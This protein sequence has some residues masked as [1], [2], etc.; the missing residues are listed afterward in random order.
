MRIA[1]PTQGTAGLDDQ[2]EEHFG[3]AQH[4]TLID[5]ENGEI[6]D[7]QVLDVPYAEHGPGDLPNWLHSQG[8][9]VVLAWGMGPRAVEFF[10]QLGIE[11]IT[12]ATGRVREVVE[13]YLRGSLETIE[14]VEP[15]GHGRGHRHRHGKG[16]GS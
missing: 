1:I 15:E 4:Y 11:V 9:D 12:G 7:V 10:E 16:P 5:I 8:V 13:G 14:W 6:T 3:R 2:V